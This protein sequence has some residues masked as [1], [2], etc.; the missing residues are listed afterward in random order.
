VVRTGLLF[1]VLQVAMAVAF[2]SDTIVL[3]QILGAAAVA[4]FAVTFKLFMIGPMLLGFVLMPLWPA[5]AD[6]LAR[7][8]GMWV[9]RTLRWTMTLAFAVTVP[10]SAILLVAGTPLIHAWA[11]DSITPPT[12]LKVAL[13]VWT[14]LLGISGALAMFLNGVGAIRFQAICATAMMVTN[15]VLSIALTKAVGMEGVVLGSIAAQT[16]CTL[17]PCSIYARRVLARV[18]EPAGSRSTA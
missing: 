17:V 7:G 2:E 12:D 1:L 6:A 10:V 13:A 4:T 5:Y 11:G 15:I 14:V 16:V 18:S 3:A 9:R 8:D